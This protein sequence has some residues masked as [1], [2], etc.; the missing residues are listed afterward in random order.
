MRAG[1]KVFIAILG[2]GLLM[3]LGLMLF[4]PSLFNQV[5]GM[6]QSAQQ[7]TISTETATPPSQDIV[8]R[9]G[10]F[11]DGDALHKGKGIVRQVTTADGQH[12]L[13]F[14][15][16]ETSVGPDVYVYLS[17]NANPGDNKQPGEHVSLGPLQSFY[18]D[19][20][21]RLPANAEEYKSVLIWCKPF[22]LAITYAVLE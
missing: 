3:G 1:N 15:D 19:Q 7:S 21:Y 6:D 5:T 20:Q 22:N 10:R 14:K 4:N 18:G 12:V 8:T 2:V 9:T 11:V 13:Q 16:F 17:K